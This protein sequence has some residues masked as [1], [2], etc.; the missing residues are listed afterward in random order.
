ELIRTCADGNWSDGAADVLFAGNVAMD[1]S[2]ERRRTAIEAAVTRIGGLDA[3]A[4]PRPQDETSQ[5]PSHLVWF[6]PGN[7]GRLRVELQLTPENPP[8]VQWLQ[9]TV[10]KG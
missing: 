4:A 6:V 5:S 8:L 10:D 7:A 3:S 9:V 2:Y 1:D